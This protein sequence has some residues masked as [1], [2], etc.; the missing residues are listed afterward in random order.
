MGGGAVKGVTGWVGWGHSRDTDALGGRVAP[1]TVAERG[2][3]GGAGAPA[4]SAAMVGSAE[5]RWWRDALGASIALPSPGDAKLVLVGE[6]RSLTRR[7]IDARL[8][9]EAALFFLGRRAGDFDGGGGERLMQWAQ[10]D[11]HEGAVSH[12]CSRGVWC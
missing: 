11:V 10:R 5:V 2:L 12:V 3:G 6:V 1:A 8:A 9:G 4:A 7:R